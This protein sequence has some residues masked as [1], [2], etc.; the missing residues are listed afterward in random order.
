MK[1]GCSVEYIPSNLVS[2]QCALHCQILCIKMRY[3]DY[4]APGRCDRYVRLILTVLCPAHRRGT[5]VHMV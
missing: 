1:Q 2:I 3:V 5:C 4:R